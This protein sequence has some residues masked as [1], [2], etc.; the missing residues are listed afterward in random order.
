MEITVTTVKGS[1]PQQAR[2]IAEEKVGRLERYFSGMERAE[3][4][5]FEEP[6]RQNSTRELCEVTM[7]GHGLVVRARG[8]GADPFAALEVAVNKLSHRLLRLKSRLVGRSHPRRA[9]LGRVK[10]AR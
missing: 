8:C 3:V 4:R 10:L 2:V 5:F 6:T 1:L 9:A 7:S